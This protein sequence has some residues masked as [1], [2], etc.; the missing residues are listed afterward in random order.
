ME[1]INNV[2]LKAELKWIILLIRRYMWM[3]P[4]IRKALVALLSMLIEVFYIINKCLEG[5]Q[6]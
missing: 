3:T 4:I 2:E 6:K 5:G 1:R